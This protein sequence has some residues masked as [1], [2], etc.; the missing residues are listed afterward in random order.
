[1]HH[2][3]C[4]APVFD[5][6]VVLDLED[7]AAPGCF[8]NS[9]PDL[10]RRASLRSSPSHGG[11]PDPESPQNLLLGKFACGA[12]KRVRIRELTIRR[13]VVPAKLE[14]GRRTRRG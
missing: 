8:R 2:V 7:E 13:S 12:Y 4:M 9:R 14:G 6:A 3:I 11:V 10:S 5:L 1:M